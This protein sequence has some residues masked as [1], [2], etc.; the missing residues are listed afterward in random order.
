M[1]DKK[2]EKNVWYYYER[3]EKVKTKIL[4]VSKRIFIRYKHN[5]FEFWVGRG[6]SE[7]WVII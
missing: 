4:S 6:L 7:I 2:D 3:F 1:N 5:K